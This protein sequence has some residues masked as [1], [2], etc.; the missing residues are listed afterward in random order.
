[1]IRVL[2]VDDDPLVLAG[3]KRL[4]RRFAQ[5]LQAEFVS[6]ALEALELLSH[7]AFDAIVSDM[8]MPNMDG[9]ELLNRVRTKYPEMVR[10]I[11]SGQASQESMFR[12]LGP[13]HRFLSKP[14]RPDE[15]FAFLIRAL[16]I[17]DRLANRELRALVG[18]IDKLPC[19][20]RV[21]AELVEELHNPRGSLDRIGRLL[22]QDVAMTAKILHIVNSSFF[23][24]PQRISS[25]SQAVCLLGIEIVKSLVLTVGV[26]S[27]FD[28]HANGAIH[29]EELAQHSIAVGTTAHRIAR[30]LGGTAHDAEEALLA[31]MMHDIGK[32]V[33]ATEKAEEYAIVKRLTAEGDCPLWRGEEDWFGT[34]HSDI[35]AYLLS[36]WGFPHSIVE[37]VA[38]HHQPSNVPIT[39][40]V[41][42]TA[43]HMANA[44]AN[45]RASD[46]KLP[47]QAF[48]DLEYLMIAGVDAEAYA[49]FARP[50]HTVV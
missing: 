3:L 34:S 29:V 5:N 24:V 37:A 40:P 14:C 36:L 49:A 32:L 1:M 28:R 44:L 17:R 50:E 27:Q 16:T 21:Y 9:A 43:V 38:F 31:G 15:L 48:L 10:L 30:D 7:E 26:F 12:A 23:G 45:E 18:K 25:P 33:L 35:G 11:L 41:T 47:A 13:A 39:S 2:F 42:L 22:S 20:P 8:R 4:M 6:S 46:G 19:L